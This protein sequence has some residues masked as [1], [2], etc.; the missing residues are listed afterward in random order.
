[1]QSA[2]PTVRVFMYI[3]ELDAFVV[4]ERYRQIAEALALD[5]WTPVCWIGR[6]FLLDNDFGEHWFDNHQ[7]R[8]RREQ[9]ARRLGI[10][11]SELLILDP[12]RMI[13]GK[14]GPCHSDDTRGLF[15]KDVLL[16]LRLSLPTLYRAA[17]DAHK[18]EP[19]ATKARIENAKQLAAA[20]GESEHNDA[21]AKGW[22]ASGPE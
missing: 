15:W 20:W 5:E 2:E 18:T 7:D 19:D 3:E 21:G 10:S 6:L 12:N 14:D 9:E 13:D 1:M 22:S 16:S 4:S 11:T 17:M 8:E